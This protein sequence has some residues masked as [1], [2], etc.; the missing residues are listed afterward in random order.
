MARRHLILFAD[1][2][3]LKRV[4]VNLLANAVKFSESG[5]RVTVECRRNAGRR[6]I[7]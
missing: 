1:E 2:T 3:A 6:R 7:A 4:L 5:T